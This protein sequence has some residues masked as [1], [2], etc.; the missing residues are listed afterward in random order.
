VVI[1]DN[2]PAAV[3]GCARL[4]NN[5]AMRPDDRSGQPP[6]TDTAGVEFVIGGG[7]A[8]AKDLLDLAAIAEIR[9]RSS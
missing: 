7:V 4:C 3:A 1:R 6:T 9:R 8:L 2:R 5:S